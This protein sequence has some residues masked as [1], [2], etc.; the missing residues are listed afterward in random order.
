MDSAARDDLYSAIA[1][2]NRGEHLAAQEQLETLY[3]RLDGDDQPLVR[4]LMLVA[5][6]MHLHFKRGGGRG[7]TNCFRQGL[8]M[9]DD[10]K[11]EREGIATG[12]LFDAL[13]AYLQELNTRRKPGAGFF[14]RWLAPKIR[15]SG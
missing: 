8:V 15:V 12:E 2:F 10:M 4:A 3:N 7:A 1:L 5:C 14:D 11:P 6:G 9:L 13:E